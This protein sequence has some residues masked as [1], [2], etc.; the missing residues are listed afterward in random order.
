[1]VN[2]QNLI[3]NQ[4]GGLSTDKAREIG[5]AGGIASGEAR[6]QRRLLRETLN[7]L[8]KTPVDD[9]DAAAALEAAGLPADLQGG[10]IFAVLKRAQT[11][12]IEA[13]R[14]IRDTLGEKPTETFNL[15]VSQK[16]IQALDL[17]QYTDAELAAMADRISDEGTAALPEMTDAELAALAGDE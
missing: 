15:A 16:P 14:Y 1:M 6:R 13:A 12:D 7:D 5:R 4:P 8:L 3:Q 9:P 17:T 2:E 10:M 11:G